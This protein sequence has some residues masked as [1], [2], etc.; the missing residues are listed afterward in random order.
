MI[1]LPESRPRPGGRVVLYKTIV[2]K[3]R[4]A[5]A[6]MGQP[7][8]IVGDLCSEWTS[9]QNAIELIYPLYILLLPEAL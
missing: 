1:N 3:L 2:A 9:M 6:A 4:L 5:M 8:R 7:E